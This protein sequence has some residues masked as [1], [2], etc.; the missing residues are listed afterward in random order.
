MERR[1]AGRR[2]KLIAFLNNEMLAGTNKRVREDSGVGIKPISITGTKR[3]VRMAIKYALENEQQVGDDCAQR[4]YPEV[5]RGRVP[6][7]GIRSCHP[8]ISQRRGHRA[9]KLDHRQQGQEP[10]PHHRRERQDD[11]AGTRV[12][13]SGL[14]RCTFGGSEGCD[15]QHLRHSWQGRVE[16]EADGQ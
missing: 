5:H 11:R 10:R 15:G 7:V 14:S 1:H 2:K 12:C 6:R 8:G 9:R 13:P 16:E 3:L 4:Q